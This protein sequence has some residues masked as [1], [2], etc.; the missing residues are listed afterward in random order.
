MASS[1]T[2]APPRRRLLWWSL[3]ALVIVVGFVELAIGSET[4]APILLI[5][6][7]CALVPIAILQ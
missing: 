7:Y 4:L 2:L 3:A 5:L 1:D 6:G